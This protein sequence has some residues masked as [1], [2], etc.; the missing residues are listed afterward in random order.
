VTFTV[1]ATGNPAPQLQ[2]ERSAD[3]TT[4]TAVPGATDPSCALDPATI[5]DD[6][7][8]FRAVASNGIGAPVAS[9][10]AALAVTYLVLDGQ[11]VDGVVEA[12]G[13]ASFTVAARGNPAPAYQWQRS[14]GGQSWADLAGAT[15]STY[16]TPATAL[17]DDGTRFR[18]RLT[19]GVSPAVTSAAA[20][21]TVHQGPAFTLQPS[22]ATVAAGGAVTFTV[23][24]T[25]NP[26]PQLQW[27]R[28]ADGT[29]WTAIPRA[30]G[31]SFPL[32]PAAAADDGARFR[33]VA[34]NGI[35]APV[36]STAAVL[37][38]T[39]L[40]LIAAP[41]NRTV[42][43]PAPATFTATAEG[44]P[45]PAYQWQRSTDGGQ[46]WSELAGATS[47]TYVTP[48]TA[49]ADH[50]TRFRVRVTNGVSADLTSAAATLTVHLHPVILIGPRSQAVSDGDTA[51]FGVLALG[52]PAPTY[53]WERSADGASWTAV[54]G[55][56]AATLAMTAA[57]ADDGLWLRVVVDNGVGAPVVGDAVR[58]GVRPVLEGHWE[59]IADGPPV[60]Q[61]AVAYDPDSGRA[62]LFGGSAIPAPGERAI[63]QTWLWDSASLT[64][65]ELAPAGD[66][67]SP[68]L[69]MDMAFDRASGEAVL[70][71]GWFS[72][73]LSDPGHPPPA[74][75]LGT[76]TF[77]LDSRTWTYRGQALGP[78][79]CFAMG[80]DT[81]AGR[82]RIFGGQT[83]MVDP[84]QPDYGWSR[85]FDQVWTWEPA[86]AQ[87]PGVQF[88]AAIGGRAGPRWAYDRSHHR[89]VL[90]G[91]GYPGWCGSFPCT[92]HQDTW[93]YDPTTLAW[94]QTTEG[95]VQP[96]ASGFFGMA[97]DA[98]RQRTVM[99]LGLA[100]GFHQLGVAS[101]APQTWEYDAGAHSWRR[102]RAA[103]EPGNL[104]VPALFF[105]ELRGEVL[106]VGGATPGGMS[107]GTYRLVPGP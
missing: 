21:L 37:T 22:G 61:P 3:G 78:V 67:P 91:G 72:P 95:D 80:Y 31:A 93:E 73:D 53:Q 42:I 24:A 33:A 89:F 36:A 94:V 49:L 52:N 106:L 82:V 57:L 71:G 1:A 103:A 45:A 63:D 102:Y 28:S 105:D 55:A 56:T 35:G 66:V 76:F 68:R 25:G 7:A 96:P 39:H 51:T 64:W 77:R 90:F 15:S 34:S 54:P 59:R 43:A 97:H 69:S 17:A 14:T 74:P 83:V 79:D 50:G 44:T 48:A 60:S 92:Y 107:A 38:V 4:W 12:P 2:W 62:V 8:R 23:A 18:A 101:P 13:T 6:G 9:A 47:P 70:H 58:L 5:A 26:A 86:T 11:P 32:D 20:L 40:R 19:N 65:T 99:Y 29:T 85:F 81:D 30:T 41:E 46:S 27:E 98:V 88:D 84:T 10:A 75:A 16:V 87:W 100:P 104:D